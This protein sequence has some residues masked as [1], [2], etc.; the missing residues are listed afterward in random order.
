R[1]TDSAES[2]R[3]LKA[4]FE[5]YQQV[6]TVISRETAPN[7]WATVCAE[8]GHTIVAALPLLS[9]D[10]RGNFVRNAVAL[11]ENARP[12]FVAGGF[13]QDLERLDGALQT[14]K[15]AVPPN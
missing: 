4:S 9:G 5:L 3:A 2:F 15:A 11:F 6:L 13:G 8:M 1:L 12:Y 7:D 10:N 14:A